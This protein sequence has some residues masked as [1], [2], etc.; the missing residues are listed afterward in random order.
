MEYYLETVKRLEDEQTTAEEKQLIVEQCERRKQ[1][2][3][4]SMTRVLDITTNPEEYYEVYNKIMSSDTNTISIKDLNILFGRVD[5]II[6]DMIMNGVCRNTPA[7]SQGYLSLTCLT[8]LENYLSI[9]ELRYNIVPKRVKLILK[10]L[11]IHMN[12]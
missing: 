9:N 1:Q 12:K 10:P 11:I 7:L 3:I 6:D 4:Q 8:M 2:W 5:G